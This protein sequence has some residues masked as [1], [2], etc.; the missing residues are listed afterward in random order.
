MPLSEDVKKI[1]EQVTDLHRPRKSDLQDLVIRRQPRPYRFHDDGQTPNHPRWPLIWYRAAVRLEAPFDP[2]AIFEELFAANGWRGSWRDGVYDFL[3]LHTH[4][5]EV[6]GIARGTARVRFGSAKGRA[7]ALKAGDVVIL[8][9]GTGHRRLA[10]SRDLLVVG[11]YPTS[12][13]QYDEPA[14]RELDPA[15]SRMAIARVKLPAKDPVY[16]RT[17]P[18]PNLWRPANGGRD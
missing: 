1:A 6:L 2:A 13:G 9:A 5:H 17:G 12:S 15:A 4:S 10:K 7:F 8:P 3:H 18:L 16:G 11:A 14:P